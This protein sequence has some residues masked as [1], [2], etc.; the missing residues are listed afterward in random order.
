VREYLVLL[1]KELR[2]ITKEKTIM[3]AVIVQFLI[4]SFSSVILEGVMTF[5]D[6][7]FIGW[8][9]NEIRVGFVGNTDTPLFEYIQDRKIVTRSFSELAAAEAAFRAGQIDAI[10]FMP[11]SQSDSVNM[12]LFLPKMEAKRTVIL[13]MLDEPLRRYED[14]LRET[15]GVLVNYK[16]FDST[17]FSTYE[18]LYTALI[19][20]LMLFPALV[21]GSIVI[22]AISEEF[23]NKTL[24]TLIS[25][26]ISARQVFASKV[27]AAVI[28]AV[29]QIMMWAGLLSWN[30]IVI[31]R[32]TLVLIL[33]ISYSVTISFGA[34]IIALFF[35]DR[36]RAQ[37][38]YSMILIAT[39]AAS[40]FLNPSPFELLTK[41][42]SGAPNTSTLGFVI[43]ALLPIAVGLAFFHLS[44]R[45]MSTGS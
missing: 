19:P 36:Q 29:V 26:P 4:A 1:K 44:E 32:L 5:Y 9:S 42:S 13:V 39:G 31:E 28:T 8:S 41:L 14:Y 3:L 27:S 11:E 25:T 16:D 18:F 40:Y 22:D 33:A 17:P 10:L 15:N 23:E 30:G 21:A 38:T 7:N 45:R 2:S 24:D 34:A 35:K 12:R 20:I 43:Y 37:F 6:P